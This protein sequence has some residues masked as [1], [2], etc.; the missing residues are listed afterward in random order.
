[1]M[2]TLLSHAPRAPPSSRV[3][4]PLR[5]GRSAARVGKS[6]VTVSSLKCAPLSLLAAGCTADAA[7][8]RKERPDVV[9]LTQNAKQTSCAQ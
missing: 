5:R 4:L 8:A 2:A 6:L 9:R 7:D 1:M 3:L